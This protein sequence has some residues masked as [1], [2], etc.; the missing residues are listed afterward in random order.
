M[1]HSQTSYPLLHFLYV[2]TSQLINLKLNKLKRTSF[3]C[4]LQPIKL[5]QFKSKAY[6]TKHIIL[7]KYHISLG[8]AGPNDKYNCHVSILY[9]YH[10]F[11]G[12]QVIGADGKPVC[13]SFISI[14]FSENRKILLCI[15]K[16]VSILYKY[17]IFLWQHL[18]KTQT[19]Q[20]VSILYKYHIFLT[21]YST[22]WTLIE[23]NI[24]K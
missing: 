7:N 5:H 20:T 12:Q 21:K 19:T 23:K 2:L 15:A 11:H 10:I 14:I 17:H 9:K 22:F 13:R 4:P 16:E 3:R 8:T 6:Y 1:K 18:Q 24:E